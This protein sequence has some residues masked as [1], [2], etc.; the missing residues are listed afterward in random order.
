MSPSVP[1]DQQ[2]L[3]IVLNGAPDSV[4]GGTSVNDLLTRLGLTKDRIAVEIDGNI[5]RKADYETVLLHDGCRVEVVSFV[6][7]G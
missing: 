7:G 5:V 4:P 3:A 2:G 6:G 1:T